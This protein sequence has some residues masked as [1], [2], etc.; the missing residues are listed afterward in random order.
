MLNVPAV[1]VIDLVEQGGASQALCQKAL[2]FDDQIENVLRA[3]ANIRENCGAFIQRQSL[4][5]IAGNQITAPDEFTG[6]WLENS[7]GNLEKS[8]FPGTV[9]TNESD[10]F[11]FMNRE[12][13]LVEHRLDAIAHYEFTRTDD[14]VR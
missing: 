4:R 10:P 14:R 13:C 6:I 3:G 8:G 1:E 9:A 11:S 2:V 12:R 5:H 7:S